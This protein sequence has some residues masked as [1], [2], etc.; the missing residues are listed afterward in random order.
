ME[1]A[2]ICYAGRVI[3]IFECDYGKSNNY[4]GDQC[5]IVKEPGSLDQPII[6][7]CAL[8]H[9]QSLMDPYEPTIRQ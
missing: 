3:L 2:D 9:L 5:V 4:N 1:V 6:S 8:L 7:E